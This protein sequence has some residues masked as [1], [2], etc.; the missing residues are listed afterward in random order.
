MSIIAVGSLAFDSVRSTA[1]SRERIL[2]GSLTHFSNAASLLS[3]PYL[4]GIVGNDFGT[5]EWDFLRRVSLSVEGVA[6]LQDEKS[7]F[8][9]GYYTED[10]DT[11]VSEVTELGAFAR[12]NPAVPESYKK[13][14]SILF[15]ANIHPAIQK[16]VADQTP[17]RLKV[18]DTM[19]YWITQEPAALAA[20]FRSVDGVVIN[21]GEAALLTGEKTVLKAAHK[22]LDEYPN[23]KLLILKK[24]SNGVM[25]FSGGVTVSLPAFPTSA[26]VDPTG[27]GDSFAGAFISYL[28]KNNVRVFDHK[29]LKAAAAYATVIASF[30]VEGFGVE[31]IARLNPGMIRER[32]A[33]YRRASAF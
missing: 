20:A 6:S 19:N 23:W 32:M 29:N 12:F 2:G 10:F 11:A 22:L 4:V 28:D 16:T 15:L 21:E 13:P 31:G 8:W 14:S 33:H 5:S 3:K 9:K 17:A 7:F 25:I 26:V 24:G 18:L 30:A 27:A 1:G